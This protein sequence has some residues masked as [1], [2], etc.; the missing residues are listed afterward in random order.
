MIIKSCWDLND[1]KKA[2][3]IFSTQATVEGKGKTSVSINTENN[4]SC[5]QSEVTVYSD[6]TWCFAKWVKKSYWLEFW[7]RCHQHQ[8]KLHPRASIRCLFR[9]I[10]IQDWIL[11]EQGRIPGPYM[12]WWRLICSTAIDSTGVRNAK[13]ERPATRAS[14]PRRKC[15]CSHTLEWVASVCEWSGSESLSEH[16]NLPLPQPGKNQWV[17]GN[18]AG[19]KAIALL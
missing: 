5:L 3:K 9:A 15:G 1:G 8:W 19:A 16:G 17:M 18:R 2:G 7:Q 13:K 4:E 12:E 6:A 10:L 14:T 11:C